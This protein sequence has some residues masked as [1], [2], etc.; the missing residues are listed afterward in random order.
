[1]RLSMASPYY[2]AW[3]SST[4]TDFEAA[5]ELVRARDFTAIAE[6]AEHSCLKMHGLMLS[7]RPG[8]LYW[9]AA[10][11]TCLHRI[12]ELRADGVPVFFTVDAGPQVKAI[13]APEAAAAVATALGE[14]PGVIEILEA[15]LGRGAWLQQ[16]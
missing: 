4:H 11:T 5:V 7:T 9:N 15:G 8:L 6:L 14:V 10:T 2:P 1:M 16:P 13:C 12:R 3:L